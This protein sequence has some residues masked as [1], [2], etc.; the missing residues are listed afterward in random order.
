M[1]FSFYLST[2]NVDEAYKSVKAIQN[3]A[4]STSLFAPRVITT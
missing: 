1:N 4:V 3:P 2:G